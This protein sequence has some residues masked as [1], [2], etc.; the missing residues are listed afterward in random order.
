METI[1][2]PP[3]IDRSSSV[4]ILALG[5]FMVSAHV[6]L[7]TLGARRAALGPAARVLSPLLF[8]AFLAVWLGIGIVAGDGTRG[9]ALTLPLLLLIGFSPVVTAAVLIAALETPR[10]LYRE[11][12]SDWLIRIQIYRLAGG[13]FLFPFLYYGIVPA[14]F[15]LPAAIGDMLTG[16][17]APLVAQAVAQRRRGAF[18]W[19]V[20]WNVFGIL[21][22]IVAPVAAV[23]SQAEILDVY[24]LVLV[25]LFIGPPLGILTHVVSLGNLFAARRR[26][27]TVGETGS[28]GRREFGV[29]AHAAAR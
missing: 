20:A 16:A 5:I 24:P 21:D 8:G 1:L 11:M 19:A 9:G 17:L 12:P 15:A 25:P 4:F 6:Y 14:G 7:A 23:L 18:G 3:W 10:T 28:R 13:M 26:G 2:L 27:W 22:L 29:H